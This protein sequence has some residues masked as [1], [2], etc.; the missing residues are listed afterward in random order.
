MMGVEGWDVNGN[1]RLRNELTADHVDA[2][3][4]HTYVSQ[5]K[6]KSAARTAWSMWNLI[7]LL[8]PLPAF[9]FQ[10]SNYK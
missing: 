10:C 2:S 5:V 8:Q 6:L 4:A 7:S 1:I 9:K 3:M